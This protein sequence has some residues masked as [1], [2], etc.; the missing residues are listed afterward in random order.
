MSKDNSSKSKLRKIF[1]ISTVLSGMYILLNAIVKKKTEPDDLD[2][3]N[4]YIQKIDTV[5]N[6]LSVYEKIVKPAMDKILSFAGLIVLSPLYG[7]ISIIVYLDDPGPVFFTQKRI[8]KDKQFFY[9]HKY[10]S[11]RMST[12]HD[13][14]THQLSNPEKYITRFGRILRKTSLDELPQIWDIFRGKMSFIGP[15]PALWN[16]EDLVAEREKYEANSIMP[17]LTG[18][19]QIKGRDELEIV[20]KAALDGEYREILRKGGLKAFFQDIKCFIGT[21][22]S[23]LKHDGVVEG[24][25]GSIHGQA[26]STGRAVENGGTDKIEEADSS[27]TVGIEYG[28]KK[29]FHIN[30]ELSKC[31]LITGANSYIGESFKTY[32]EI[33]YPDIS[34]DTVDM[35]DDSWKR[36]DFSKFDTVF[37]VAGIA[38][39]DVG[40]VSE[41]EKQKYYAVNAGLAVET[42]A[43]AKKAGVSQFIFMSSMIIY[44]AS[45]PHGKCKMIDENTKP[46][47]ENFYGDS[48]WRGD[49]GVRK[50][51]DEN[52]HV[53]VL[54]PPMIYGDGCKGNYAALST[55]AKK[56]LLF[57]NIENRRSMLYI[58]NLCEFIC[59]LTLSGEGGIYFPQNREYTK[60]ADMVKSIAKAS[61]RNIYTVRVLN[62]TVAVASHIPGKIGALVNKAF[63]NNVYDQ[64]LSTYKGLDYRVA[65]LENSIQRTENSRDSIDIT[66]GVRAAR[67]ENMNDEAC[68]SQRKRRHILVISQYFWPETFRINDIAS[69][70]VKRGYQ[71][72]VLTGIPNY[73]TGKFFEGYDYRHRRHEYWN[74]IEI[75]RIPLIPRGNSSIGMAANYFSFTAM[76]FWWKNVTDI[77]AD[78]VF[79]FE[80]SP[81]TQALI[82]C[83]YS[84]KYH[85]PHFLYVQDLWPENVETVAGITNPVIIK[86]I[87]RMVDYIYRNTDEIFAT[88]PSFVEAIVNRNVS[89]PREK[90]HYWPQY[91]EEFYKVL[92][93]AVVREN[94][95]SSSPVHRIPD[96]ECFNIIFTGNIGTAQGL[97][98]LPKTAELLKLD[99]IR[100]VIVGDGRYQKQFEGEIKHRGVE[101][102][103]VMIPKQPAEI[104]PELLACCDAAFLSF[105]DTE[106]FEKTIPAKLQSYM[107][108]GMPII[109]AAKGDTERLIKEAE[110]GVCV[111]IGEDKALASAI[112][113]LR[114][115]KSEVEIMRKNSH[116]NYK[117]WF[118]KSNLMNEMDKYIIMQMKW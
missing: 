118:N 106:L 34:I 88:S 114:E 12:P 22:E 19:A 115:N 81:M 66:S 70:W 29:T 40:A 10:R 105:M 52:F 95:V 73:P 41:K 59:L 112:N 35:I 33:H 16:Q 17:G 100:F 9:L 75:I 43:M 79:T 71:V 37:H 92:D 99:N 7:V 23:V 54:R 61:G 94:A 24:G 13:V 38:H 67:F 46:S 74:G 72:T 50:L 58:E 36:H 85:V 90:V 108:C 111:P 68:V 83:W 26:D 78:L 62:P 31:V 21:I 56:L 28:H 53:A 93:R 82:G 18:I 87:H 2:K 5:S 80:V 11:M 32:A 63:G 116:I 57:P 51:A 39:A 109:A 69:E 86:S 102:K 76:G 84:R 1:L 20:D 110:C 107:A 47:P 25:T 103:F 104:I 77:R 113:W 27:D 14:P 6:S 30:R 65:D 44:G 97:E 64:K 49:V 117:N 42:A 89:V 91:A 55:L 4:P 3:E 60:T 98:I 15:R 101:D 8:G 45:A 96:D 48:K